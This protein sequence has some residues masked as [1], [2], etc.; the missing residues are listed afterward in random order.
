MMMLLFP[1]IASVSG[2]R[3]S[4]KSKT[5]LNFTSEIKL[6]SGRKFKAVL[7]PAAVMKLKSE[8]HSV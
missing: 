2:H 5:N 8:K 6:R 1:F 3:P 7:K 4:R